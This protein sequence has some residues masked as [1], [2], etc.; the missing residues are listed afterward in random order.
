MEN[1]FILINH[2]SGD[3]SRAEGCETLPI[4]ALAFPS[5]G[6]GTRGHRRFSV[7]FVGF[8]LFFFLFW[9]L[10]IFPADDN[11]PD[12]HKL[13]GFTFFSLLESSV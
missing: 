6:F 5:P 9:K 7:G 11:I 2:E 8:S 3:C 10:C 13:V 1:C 4:G 12:L